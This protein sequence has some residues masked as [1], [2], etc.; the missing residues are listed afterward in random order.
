[1]FVLL[2]FPT[3]SL[4]SRRWRPVAW[5]AAAAMVGWVLGN[6]F[7]PAPVDGS[8][9]HNPIAMGGPAGHAIQ[10]LGGVSGLMIGAA[11]I[12][13]IVSLAFRYRRAR[14]VEREQL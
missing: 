8:L 12:A 7:A 1:V 14:T 5:T 10:T 9:P 13:A 3:G 6:T 4:P 11:G 2:L